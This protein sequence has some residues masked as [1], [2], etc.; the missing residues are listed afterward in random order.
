MTSERAVHLARVCSF[1]QSR[2]RDTCQGTVSRKSRH[3]GSAVAQPDPGP[4]GVAQGGEGATALE[5][6]P[7]QDQDQAHGGNALATLLGCWFSMCLSPFCHCFHV[8]LK[9]AAKAQQASLTQGSD[10]DSTRSS[11]TETTT[12]RDGAQEA[13]KSSTSIVTTAVL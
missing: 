8:R 2:K 9:A 13:V 5:S 10:R 3:L 4:S 7:D 12:C 1:H 11:Y 6:C